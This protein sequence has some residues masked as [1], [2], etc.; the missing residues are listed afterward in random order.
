MA[1]CHCVQHIPSFL[2]VFPPMSHRRHPSSTSAN[3]TFTPEPNGSGSRIQP[4]HTPAPHSPLVQ[5]L[6]PYPLPPIALIDLLYTI[7]HSTAFDTPN[8]LLCSNV[9]RAVVFGGVV[10]LSRKWR[11]RGGWVGVVCGLTVGAAVWEGCALRLKRE[12]T[13]PISGGSV[14]SLVGSMRP[15]FLVAVSSGG[16]QGF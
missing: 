10:G 11:S 7:Q 16:N 12:K 14:E 2:T 4:L 5:L 8:C 3:N 9:S 13:H 1:T 15:S 6:Y